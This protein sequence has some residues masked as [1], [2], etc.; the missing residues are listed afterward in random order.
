MNSQARCCFRRLSHVIRQVECALVD[1]SL[2]YWSGKDLVGTKSL[3]RTQRLK[4]STEGPSDFIVVLMSQMQ[5]VH[6]GEI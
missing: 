1:L 4:E 6:N 3:I 5:M 2:S